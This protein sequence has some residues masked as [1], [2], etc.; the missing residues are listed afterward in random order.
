MTVQLPQR[1][2]TQ[3]TVMIE[4]AA[5]RHPYPRSTLTLDAA[6]AAVVKWEPF[7]GYNLGRTIRAWV[8]PVHTGEAGGFIGQLI[9]ALASA[10]GALLVYTGLSLAWRRWWQFVRRRRRAGR[11]VG[12]ENHAIASPQV[13]ERKA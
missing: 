6:T 5:S 12:N 1:G 13:S 8:R 7:A 10:G 2:S 3:V 4:E 9:A 11:P